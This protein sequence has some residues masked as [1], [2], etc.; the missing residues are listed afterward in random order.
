M[1][2]DAD[3]DWEAQEVRRQLAR[4]RR[5]LAAAWNLDHEVVLI[6]A[7]A[8][9]AVPGR[10]DRTYPFRSHS[11]YLYLTDRERPDGVLAYDPKEGWVDFVTPVTRHERLWEGADDA[12]QDGT[13]PVGEL[14]DW[15]TRR[16]SRPVVCLGAPIADAP[17]GDAAREEQL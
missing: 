17:A 13:V 1:F 5:D 14:A 3:A 8:P 6:G 7:G 4:R 16:S 15:L 9:V 11:E 2:I 10:R 12:D